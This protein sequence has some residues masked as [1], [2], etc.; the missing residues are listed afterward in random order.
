MRKL[1]LAALM[2]F[3]SFSTMLLTSCVTTI[4]AQDEIY[5]DEPMATQTTNNAS[6]EMVITCGT[7]YV[8]DGLV[9]YY[10]YR[11][12]YYYPYYYRNYLYY[13]VY[14]RPLVTY[15][16]YWRP[17][18]KSYWF[19]HG[20]FYKPKRFDHRH[21]NEIIRPRTRFGRQ[22][23]SARPS[24]TRMTPTTRPRNNGQQFGRPSTPRGQGMHQRTTPRSTNRGNFGGRR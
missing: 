17:L 3:A 14:E 11:G 18:P 19:R 24:S 9:H 20:S 2:V 4:A 21:Y 23:P 13:R 8:I 22:T 5:G 1:V 15:P 10:M 7:P 16:R 12:L 6:I